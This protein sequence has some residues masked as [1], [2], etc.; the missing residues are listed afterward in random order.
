MTSE[1]KQELMAKTRPIRVLHFLNSNDVPGGAEEQACSLLTG[2]P[3]DRFSV[4]FVCPP[5]PYEMLFASHAT[6]ER[7]VVCLD[8]HK[9]SQVSAMKRLAR[10]LRGERIDIAHS[11]QFR[12]TAILAPLAKLCGVPWVVETTHVRE[13]WRRSWLKRSFL[14]DRVAYTMVDQFIAVSKANSDY[15][16][17]QKH[18]NPAK[19]EVI[20]NG[21]DLSHFRPGVD[22]YAPLRQRYGVESSS[23]LIVHI[24]RL[25]PQKGH[26]VLLEA[27]PS[28][29]QRYPDVKLLMVGDGALRA[30]I[31]AEIRRLNLEETVLLAGF[32][33]DVVPFLGA[34]DLVVLPSLWEG[35]PLIAIEAGAMGKA[36]VATNVDGTPEVIIDGETGILVPP[37]NSQRLAEAIV[38]L[39]GDNTKRREMGAKALQ[40]T[41]E[42]FSL[43]RQVAETAELYIRLMGMRRAAP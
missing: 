26:M 1:S 4:T 19:V 20:H 36:M 25:E 3:P 6:A 31:E 14:I 5:V 9:F 23:L 7:H 38:T 30:V 16:V 28:V 29:L 37:G 10:I 42:H 18:C 2:L 33:T 21:R 22:G 8:L 32:Q 15:L 35:L 12:A 43:E 24:G 39:L 27:M 17:G 13:A 34:A 41:K 11:H 40:I